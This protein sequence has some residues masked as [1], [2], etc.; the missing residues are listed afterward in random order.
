MSSEWENDVCF[1]RKNNNQEQAIGPEFN[2]WDHPL[3]TTAFGG[4]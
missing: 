3:S 4:P 1:L 2:M